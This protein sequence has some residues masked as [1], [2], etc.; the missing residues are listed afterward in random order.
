MYLTDGCMSKHREKCWYDHTILQKW[1]GISSLWMHMLNA[2]IQE[3][4]A[5]LTSS[6]IQ[7]IWFL[8]V[9]VL[10]MYTYDKRWPG[11]VLPQRALWTQSRHT[12]KLQSPTITLIHSTL[13]NIF[14]TTTVR[15]H[16]HMC[17]FVYVFT[18]ITRTILQVKI[19][20]MYMYTHAIHAVAVKGGVT[21]LSL[22]ASSCTPHL[23]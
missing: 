9:T 4:I 16:V 6:A 17:I 5:C 15:V 21:D 12:M 2:N 8:S 1:A 18:Y 3:S 20:Y 14:L 10:Y 7:K 11:R 22:S 19:L 13:C 23:L